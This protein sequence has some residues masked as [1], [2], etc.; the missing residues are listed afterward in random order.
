[1]AR[2]FVAQAILGVLVVVGSA[3]YTETV[4]EKLTGN[5]LASLRRLGVVAKDRAFLSLILIFSLLGMAMM[6]FVSGSS[7]IYQ[8][9]FGVSSEAYS[10]FFAIFA[11]SAAA[12]AQLYVALTEVG[13]QDHH[14]VL[15]PHGHRWVARPASGRAG[16]LGLHPDVPSGAHRLQLPRPPPPI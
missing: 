10:L 4:G 13:A 8:E 16:T 14:L 12:E 1:M 2:A 5:P 7:Y 11:V 3:L 15:R 6:A 9:G